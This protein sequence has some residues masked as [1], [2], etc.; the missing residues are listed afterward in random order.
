MP[1]FAAACSAWFLICSTSRSVTREM[2]PS[3][4]RRSPRSRADRSRRTA[5]S[6]GSG[7]GSSAA[8]RR[9]L[10][11]TRTSR[12]SRRTSTTRSPSAAVTSAARS[13][14]RVHQ[15]QAGGGLDRRA[16]QRAGALGLLVARRGGGREVLPQLG[17]VRAEVHDAIVASHVTSVKDDVVSGYARGMPDIVPLRVQLVA[18]TEFVAPDDVPWSTDADGGQ[19]LAE[20]AG[21]AC[22][23][24]WTQAQPAHR[25]QRGLPAPHPRGRAPV[26]ARARL[27]ELLPHRRVALA[28]PRADPAPALLLQPAL[29]ALRARARTPRWSSPRSSRP[30]RSC[31]R[32]SPR[33]PRRR[34]RRTRSCWRGWRSAS[35]TSRTRTLRRK[36]ARQAARAILPNATETRIVV[37]GNYRAW[38]HFI[39][40]RATEH[41]DVEIRALAVECLRQLQREVRQRV[42]RLRDRHPATTAPR[43]RPARSSRRAS[44]LPHRPRASRRSPAPRLL[45]GA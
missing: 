16:E 20:F 11:A 17:D 15:G 45:S 23:Q 33:P 34:S 7:S 29:A 1:W 27:G 22:Y 40:M 26:G 28:H 24:S 35:P 10:T 41:A 30:T 44:G 8:D 13:D 37:T 38:R 12:P 19:A 4:R 18:K 36:Q 21:R 9:T 6:R 25:H 2:S 42:R 3:R 14:E 39:A 31:T 5:T 43:S 32:C